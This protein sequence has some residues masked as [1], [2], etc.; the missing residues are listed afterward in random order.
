MCKFEMQYW[1]LPERQRE[2]VVEEHFDEY[3]IC[4]RVAFP[5]D[6]L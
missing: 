1:E 2:P 3:V 5:L 6:R 4:S